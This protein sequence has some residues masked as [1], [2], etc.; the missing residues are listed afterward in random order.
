MNP[1]EAV[2]RAIEVIQASPDA[3]E[4]VLKE[5]LMKR[6][7]PAFIADQLLVLVPLAFSR[8]W[9]IQT[10]LENQLW[11]YFLLV[12]RRTKKEE[13][14]RLDW[15]PFYGV[16]QVRAHTLSNGTPD[17]RDRL[18]AVAHHSSEYQAIDALLSQL[19]PGAVPQAV[20]TSP[21]IVLTDFPGTT[22]QV[23][24]RSTVQA[25]E[26]CRRADQPG[27]D[28]ALGINLVIDSEHP[29]EE[30]IRH[31]NESL[32]D[33]LAK[34]KGECKQMVIAVEAA[35]G[36]NEKILEHCQRLLQQDLGMDTV[37]QNLEVTVFLIDAATKAEKQF[38][39][40]WQPDS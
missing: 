15:N 9:F 34:R 40:A 8:A 26:G 29:I 30:E 20:G 14:H 6:G 17:D 31:I 19:P 7:V 23:A 13:K 2:D 25:Q 16:A 1:D 11:N 35:P 18:R 22:S 10:R 5:I 21:V 27:K 37:I 39:L 36:Q 28:C 33:W 12:D 38:K 24:Y 32:L 3:D 4:P